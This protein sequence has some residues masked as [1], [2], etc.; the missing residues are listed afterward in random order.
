MKPISNFKHLEHGDHLCLLY[1]S[2][3][4]QKNAV[5]PFIKQ[6]LS[7][8]ELCLY[9]AD[10]HMDPELADRLVSD[11][12]DLL[13]LREEGTI[14]LSS[15][16]QT[17]LRYARF[18]PSLMMEFFERLLNETLAKEFSGLRIMIDMSWALS[19]GCDQLLT[20]EALL[21]DHMTPW[22]MTTLCQYPIDR[23]AARVLEDALRT[24]P[25][26]LI[27]EHV[28]PN[29]YCEPTGFILNNPGTDARVEWMMDTLKQAASMIGKD[30]KR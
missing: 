20:F 18:E 13:R 21:N 2:V 1:R 9:I 6:G 26:A 4:E 11:G 12:I 19:I 16:Y 27:G 7:R 25:L 15:R 3:E 17:F 28:C 10:E 8:G 23:F 24:H 22:K 5:S 30:R 14:Q 29:F